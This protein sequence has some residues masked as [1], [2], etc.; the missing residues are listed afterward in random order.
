MLA[1]LV[2]K[3]ARERYMILRSADRMLTQGIHASIYVQIAAGEDTSSFSRPHVKVASVSAT[4]EGGVPT[5][6]AR[7]EKSIRGGRGWDW[8]EFHQRLCDAQAGV[9]G[10]A[11]MEGSASSRK[12]VK[13]VRC[14]LCPKNCACC[15]RGQT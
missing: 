15:G 9:H 6:H 4:V 8:D 10:D 7:R 1:S 2:F 11:L 13:G 12:G 3:G 14:L 5:T